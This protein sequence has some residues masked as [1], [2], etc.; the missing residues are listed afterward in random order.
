MVRNVLKLS[1]GCRY[2]I[3]NWV[4][5]VK[6]NQYIV[7]LRSEDL[8]FSQIADRLGLTTSRVCQLYKKAREV[9]D[10]KDVRSKQKDQ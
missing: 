2:I 10:G 8:T 4:E 3:V 7:K 1:H 6:R 9:M 5:R